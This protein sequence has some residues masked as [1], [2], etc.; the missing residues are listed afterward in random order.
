MIKCQCCPLSFFSFVVIKP[1]LQ[2][3]TCTT[4]PSPSHS[5]SLENSLDDTFSLFH[6]RV[7]R[8]P[9]PHSPFPVSLLLPPRGC[10]NR[11]LV[12]GCCCALLVGLQEA[13]YLSACTAVSVVHVC[14]C[15]CVKR[16]VCPCMCFFLCISTCLRV[17]VLLCPAVTL[18]NIGGNSRGVQPEQVIK[19]N[20]CKMALLLPSVASSG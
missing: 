12:A 1:K 10:L 14:S 18:S 4:V 17:F 15:S 13:A 7:T 2:S 9:P 6:T 20:P 11:W 3:V 8:S 16:P 5:L 19:K